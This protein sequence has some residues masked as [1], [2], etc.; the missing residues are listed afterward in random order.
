MTPP[1]SSRSSLQ[2]AF[3][4][5]TRSCEYSGAIVSRKSDPGKSA[6]GSEQG[7]GQMERLGTGTSETGGPDAWVGFLSNFVVTLE[8]EKEITREANVREENRGTTPNPKMQFQT[9]ALTTL[10]AALAAAAPQAQED[11]AAGGAS[12]QQQQLLSKLPS[13]ALPLPAG[14]LDQG[15]L[16]RRR[17]RLHLHQDGRL[18]PGR[19]AVRLQGLQARGPSVY[20]LSSSFSLFLVLV[21]VHVSLRISRRQER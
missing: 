17:L 18:H 1:F 15:Q 13:C 10:L 8:G 6:A 4:W 16:R 2:D 7:P 3:Q 11:A 5:Q 12:Q 21:P 20:V 9:L 14:G 19:P